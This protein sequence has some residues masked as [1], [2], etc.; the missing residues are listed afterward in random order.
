[1]GK[2]HALGVGLFL[3]SMGCGRA[4]PAAS[5]R[6][7][8][9]LVSAGDAFVSQ[10][11]DRSS[12]A[13]GNG[14]LKLTIGLDGQQNFRIV[15]LAN[16]RAGTTWEI[17]PAPDATVTVGGQPYALGVR[18]DGFV[19]EQAQASTLG[20]GV[21]L[22]LTFTLS[23]EGLRVTRHYACYPAA[24]AIEAWTALAATGRAVT[25]SD[26]SSWQLAVG[27]GPVHWVTGHD[28]SDAEGG[29]FTLRRT[30]LGAGERLDLAALGRSSELAVPYFAIE[31]PGQRFFGGI[32]W[33]GSW[34]MGIQRRE[35]RLQVTA[36]LPGMSTVVSEADTIETPHGFFGLATGGAAETAAALG[37]FIEEGLRGERPVM[38]LVTYN[39]W[40]AYGTRMNEVS[41]RAEM[42]RAARLG[43]E[44]FV[45][46]AGWWA[47]ADLRTA[48]DYTGGLGTWLPDS[49]RFPSGLGALSDHAHG[50]GLKFGIWVEPE[51]VALST[52]GRPGLA[53]EAW[54]ATA[55]GRYDPQVPQSEAVGAQVCL[56]DP[57]ARAWV[58]DRLVQVIDTAR[59]DYL[60][61]DNNAWINCNRAGHEHG[62]ADGNYAHVHNL[63]AVLAALRERYPDLLIENVSGGGRRLD[64]GM[65]RYT[66][67][68]WMDDH[69]APSALVRHN[70]E[71]LTAVFPPWYLLSFVTNDDPEPVHGGPD[72]H[73]Y[74]LSRMPGALG[75]AF[76]TDILSETEAAT[77]A[78]AI[79]RYK[80]TRAALDGASA[81]LLTEQAS[82]DGGPPWDVVEE[83]GATGDAAVF[84][85]QNDPSSDEVTVRLTGL[86]PAAT[87]EVHS[88][89]GEL[90]A[91]A[92]GA[93]LMSEGLT[94]GPSAGSASQL[95]TFTRA[96]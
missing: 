45:L 88:V 36:G 72:L 73:L 64:L 21:H 35:G 27:A 8:G 44:L 48:Y 62:P 87:Y 92:T 1:M 43:V 58:L 80:A 55:D 14:G 2:G 33:S 10:G 16:P 32:M 91:S 66:D 79:G 4:S 30:T 67:V 69:T 78:Q 93:R 90:I 19:F 68:G 82:A 34:A 85:F 20:T 23:R 75:L 42:A 7:A 37:S 60:K 52:V 74:A 28:A 17:A 84:A 49:R 47:G 81:A 29:G 26:L 56:A 39:T 61:W 25:V 22:A 6:A 54:L 13:I 57:A 86:D 70:L 89:D 76:R 53:E 59:P 83:L 11:A 51:R 41:A 38:P 96:Q 9:T 5:G 71:G 3:L 77:L 65:V 50:L 94:V 18:S 46:D 15:E 12:W 95:L 63:Y 31:G 24:P 40:F